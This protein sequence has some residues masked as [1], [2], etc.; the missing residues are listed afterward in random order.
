MKGVILHGGSGSRLRPFTYSD[1]KQ[2]LPVAGKPTSEYALRDMLDIG[3]EEIAIIIGNIGGEEVKKYYGNGDKWGVDINY[4][5]QDKPLGIAQAISLAEEFIGKSD[6]VVYLG[7]NI[8]Q[9][10]I[11]EA[12]GNFEV[13]QDAHVQIVKVKD[14][15]RYGV[16]YVENGKIKNLVEK[17]ARPE[18]NMALVGVYFLRPNIF[19]ILKELKP[20]KR[21]EL[22]ITDALMIMVERNMKVGFSEV[23]GW[24]KDTGSPED[25]LDCN[26]LV[27]DEIRGNL[28]DEKI[29]G[30]VYAEEGVLI[31][32]K[33]KIF[34]PAYVGRDTK[35]ENSVIRP[36]TS[37][38][39][40]CAIKN[41]EIEDSVLMDNVNARFENTQII[42]DSLIGYNSEVRT[43]QHRSGKKRMIIGRDSILEI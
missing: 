35:I 5:Y 37:I 9:N 23:K 10:G 11:K 31:D 8:V 24:W 40:N 29:F 4:I 34:G 41:A 21:N 2:L 12:F 17:P 1:V 26:R 28:S 19:P 36:Y 3:I 6:F 30:R 25:F 16:V 15:S 27:L 42:S 33:S 32:N 14:P 43:N 13:E 20:S 18:S 7:D 39:R 38:G 22:E